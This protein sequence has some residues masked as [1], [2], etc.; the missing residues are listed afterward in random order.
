MTPLHIFTCVWGAKHIQLFKDACAHS[1]G[2]PNNR[3]ALEGAV[4]NICVRKDDNFPV[5]WLQEQFPHIT[6]KA[7]Q[8][9]EHANFTN[10]G[11]D[12]G[13]NILQSLL[14]QIDVCLA[15]RVRL[16]LAPPD[17]IFAEGTVVNLL[18]LSAEPGTCVSVAHPRV[19]PGCLPLSAPL[20]SAELVSLAVS[21]G[22][23]CWTGAEL[24]HPEQN[25]FIGGIA[26]RKLAGECWAVQHRLP[27][28]YLA[29]FIESDR[30]FFKRQITFG[31]WDH[32]WPQELYPQ[33]RIRHVGS[34]DVAFVCEV[35]DPEANVPPAGAKADAY[36]ESLLH[37]NINRQL[38]TIYR[39]IK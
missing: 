9:T 13:Q 5:D 36:W 2:W 32:V 17:T 26:W 20:N 25:S 8:I 23:K 33:Q 4:W 38:L 19:L 11:M 16:L 7:R 21:H 28:V 6:V 37:H 34:S 39:G 31:A 1:L 12:I 35:T 14:Q 24:G 3:T 10:T 15:L 30:D 22:H 29:Q 18:A 27:T